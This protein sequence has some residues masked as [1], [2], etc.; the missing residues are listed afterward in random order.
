MT[1]AGKPQGYYTGVNQILLRSVPAGARRLLDVGCAEGRLGAALKGLDPGR[2]VHGIER[3]PDVAARAA[4]HLDR[5]FTLDV[6]RDD[7]PLPP[8]SLDCILYGDVLEHLQDPGAVL[9]RHRKLLAPGGVILCSIP[10]AQHHSLLRAALTGDWQ[11]T[12]SGLLDATHLRFF[13]ASTALKL[14]LDAGFAPD[15]VGA[16]RVPCPRDLYD[17]VLP[18]AQHLGLHPE[19]AAHFLSAYQHILQGTPYPPG[20]P[21]EE[22]PEEPV[23]FVV[24]VSDEA[25]LQANLLNSPCLRPGSPH[26][27]LGMGGCA[28][29]AEGLNRGLARA[30]HRLVLCVHQDVYLPR[31]WLGRYL[32]QYRRAEQS[33]GPLGVVGVYGVTRGAGGPARAGHVADRYRLLRESP[34]LPALVETL[35]EVLLAVP[36][37][38]GL[39]FD[40]RF[41]FHFYGADICLEARRRG[42][43]SVAVD[44]LLLH[45]SRGYGV[46]PE[47]FFASGSVLA[48]KWARELPLATSCAVIDT[49]GQVDIW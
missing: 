10:N 11:Y 32:H 19:R 25:T 23:S 46:P 34:P 24:C 5:V 12:Q 47:P 29:A 17:A 3:E 14:L 21:N 28:S 7:P 16:M 36:K 1:P 40:P 48:A 22:V 44:A 33:Y 37:Q 6:E 45:N 4:R 15:F 39:S 38:A 18:L 31:G 27:V 8:G 20:G 41:G 30:R 35:D 13:T 49:R 2:V 26:E 43:A 42:L 9:R